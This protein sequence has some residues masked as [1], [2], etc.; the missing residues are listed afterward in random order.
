MEDYKITFDPSNI[1]DE[2]SF[3]GMFGISLVESSANGFKFIALSE[4]KKVE[5]KLQ[6]EEKRLLISP[7]LIPNQKIY[8]DWGKDGATIQFSEEVIRLASQEFMKNGFH[9]NSKIEHKGQFVEGVSVVETWIVESVEMDKSKLY[10]F[11]VPVGTLMVTMKVDSDELWNKYIKTGKVTGFSIDGLFGMSKVM[12]SVE[13]KINNKNKLKKGNMFKDM[14]KAKKV[15]LA[16]EYLEIEVEGM[17]SLYAEAFEAGFLVLS[18]VDGVQ[19]PLM[20]ASWEYEGMVYTTDEAGLLGEVTEVPTETE[21]VAV[22]LAKLVK[23]EFAKIRKEL[24]LNE[25]VDAIVDVVEVAAE[26]AGAVVEG[27]EE[28][29]DVQALKDK[30]AELQAIIEGLQADTEEV[31]AQVVELKSQP[32]IKKISA[33]ALAKDSNVKMTKAERRAKLFGR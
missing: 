27:V 17:G 24:K 19:M 7:V 6:S 31:Q 16:V 2:E 32:R 20:S 29:E 14:F 30:I 25:D 1:V 13:L 21:T 22:E 8:R 23:I 9:T 5:L 12:R 26:E 4:D 11:D 33:I 3:E 18:E 15:E 28:E 10:G